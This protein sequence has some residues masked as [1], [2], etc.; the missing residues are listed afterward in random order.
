[1]KWMPAVIACLLPAGLA[2]AEPG[3]INTAI[4]NYNAA[5]QG[6]TPEQKIDAAT[7]LGQA[8]LANPERADAGQLAYEAGQTLC[9]QADCAGA[10][11]F[12]DLAVS[13]G[14][15]DGPLTQAD[16]ELLKA[17]T[18]WRAAPD[19]STRAALDDALTAKRDTDVSL[20][21]LAAFNNRYV[22]DA[23]DGK[24]SSAEEAAREAGAHFEPFKS[25]IAQYWSEA[26][27]VALTSSFNAGP[28]TDDVLDMARHH[29]AL[30]QLA[31]QYETPPDWLK[32]HYYT[33]DAWQ[34]SLLAYFMSGGNEKKDGRRSG[35]DTDTLSDEVDAILETR[36]KVSFSRPAS[37]DETGPD[38][39][40]LCEGQFRMKPQLQYPYRAARKGMYGSVIVRFDLEE[41]RVKSPE[42]LAAVPVN[43]FE[44][45]VT[46]TLSK[47]RW[48]AKEGKPGE[49]CRMSRTNIVMP[50][51][52]ALDG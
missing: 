10:A 42:V 37:G 41:G 2:S 24:W 48:I 21:S 6:G 12:A 40:P 25:V 15:G 17:Y 16:A 45:E 51:I 52:F 36:E 39:L 14:I 22:A 50:F 8:A 28:Q 13:A 35:P 4:A 1:M 18:A 27:I 9:L 46:A 30:T 26:E 5:A 44:E 23:G 20:L 29:V 19:T 32:D 33:T 38:P 34:M 43:R 49:T 11:P 31:G 3:D 47:W 7:A